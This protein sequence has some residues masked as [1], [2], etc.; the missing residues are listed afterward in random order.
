MVIVSAR[1]LHQLMTEEIERLSYHVEKAIRLQFSD[2]ANN[3]QVVNWMTTNGLNRHK[4]P[5]KTM[6]RL[7]AFSFILKL[8]ITESLSDALELPSPESLKIADV[9]SFFNKINDIVDFKLLPHS[10]LDELIE[11]VSL[12]IGP[13]MKK[14]REMLKLM[15][16]NDDHITDVYNSIISQKERRKLGQFWTPGYIANFMV[17]WVLRSP[18]D[19]L[20]E[21][22]TGP[23]IFLLYGIKK[24]RELGQKKESM[25]NNLFGV[26]LAL[27][28]YLIGAANL[29]SRLPNAKGNITHDD[30]L[31]LKPPRSQCEETTLDSFLSPQD[32]LLFDAIVFNPP[33]TRHHLLPSV[34][35]EELLTEFRERFGVRV[36]R[37]SSLFVYFIFHALSFL[38]KNGRMAFITPTIVFESRNS[39]T[40]KDFLR[41]NC[42]IKAIISFSEEKN[43]FQGVDAAA[44]ITLLENSIKKDE[45][46]ALVEINTW[47][48]KQVILDLLD[49][50]SEGKWDWGE[51]KR[52]S[53]AQLDPDKNWARIIRTS[54]LM[55]GPKFTKIGELAYTVRG[56]ATGANDF[57]TLTDDEVEKEAI[58]RSFLKPVLTRTR[59]AL[60]YVFD[61]DDF[62]RLGKE[63]RKR[64]LLYCTKSDF[65]RL[66]SS[67][68]AKYI[69]KGET[70]GL[71]MRSLVQTRKR[72]YYMEE[73]RI[74]PIIYTYL[75]RNRARFILNKSGVLALNAFLL[76]YPHKDIMCDETTLKA[77]LA[78]LNS[79]ITRKNLRE[80]G[81][82]YGGNTIKLEPREL[83]KTHVLD[84][85]KLTSEQRVDLAKLFDRLCEESKSQNEEQIKK[86][87]DQL[88]L[89]Y[90]N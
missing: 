43:V 29:L 19:K 25:R 65:D 31:L 36:S 57:F 48:S 51:I 50:S 26:E 24:L 23:G 2:F 20:L 89:E 67:N 87:I 3:P 80:A 17:D 21:P 86:E 54:E 15:R 9:P 90:V 53:V 8:I 81:R 70:A 79:G 46:I 41:K 82:S 85:T 4:D 40:L 38:K 61:N 44:C 47:P 63:K 32:T 11:L 30:F 83:D 72:W 34:Y 35:K 66:N 6:S 64:W 76:V 13:T 58:E 77:F 42:Q 49:G 78:I 84:P 5:T 68:V 74:P 56:I 22:G 71:H 52:I 33:Y 16:A 14:V 39:R 1:L 28:P 18:N 12:P 60:G 69:S 73:R 88:I 27:V 7:A 37:L 10:F 75:S 62:E 55:R 59:Y 45:K